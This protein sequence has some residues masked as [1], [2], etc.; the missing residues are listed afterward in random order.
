MA[1]DPRSFGA[2]SAMGAA[3]SLLATPAAAA[4]LPLPMRVEVYDADGENV[5][6]DR[7]WHRHRDRGGVD[8]GDVIAGVLVLGAIAAIADAA[9]KDRDRPDTYPDAGYGT[10]SEGERFG[11]RGLDRA[12][13]M[14]VSEVERGGERVDTVDAAQRDAQGW[15]VS[16][17]LIRGASYSCRI[18]SDGRI[19]DIGVDGASGSYGY[20]TAQGEPVANGQYDDD[21][22]A[23]ARGGQ[24]DGRYEGSGEP[25]Y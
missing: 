18:G 11:S 7:R 17:E 15:R 12:V 5:N 6:R 10:Q 4:D 14:C 9:I 20:G 24:Y 13:D 25:G 8:A 1:L 16:G 2:A 19:I 22:Y 3:L 23:D 21:Y